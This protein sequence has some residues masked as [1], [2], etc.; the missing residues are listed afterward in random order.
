ML[1]IDLPNKINSIMKNSSMG[2]SKRCQTYVK[3]LNKQIELIAE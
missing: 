3:K 1:S 2:Q